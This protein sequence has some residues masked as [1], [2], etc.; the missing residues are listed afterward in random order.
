L[1][2]KKQYQGLF[3]NPSPRQLYHIKDPTFNNII[4]NRAS[5]KLL[6][7]LLLMA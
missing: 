7:K 6:I 3:L 5:C 2:I 1:I 4:E